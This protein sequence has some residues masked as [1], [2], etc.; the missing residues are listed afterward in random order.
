MQKF[1]M[2]VCSHGKKAQV[3]RIA[4]SLWLKAHRGRYAVLGFPVFRN[5]LAENG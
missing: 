1:E 3:S 5:Y 4:C 2:N